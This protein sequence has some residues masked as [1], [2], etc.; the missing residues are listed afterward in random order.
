MSTLELF[1]FG[2]QGRG[3]LAGFTGSGP[4]A[5][6]VGDR[7]LAAWA[8]FAHTGDPSTAELGWPAHDPETR[9]T[10]VFDAESRVEHAP[11]DAERAVVAAHGADPIG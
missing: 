4:D 1:V 10:L 2:V 5:D 11:A 9:P 3:A 7:M 8:A 6:R